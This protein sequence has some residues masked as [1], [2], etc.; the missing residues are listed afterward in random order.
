MG[1][2]ITCKIIKIIEKPKL[3][4]ELTILGEHM[5]L[6]NHLLDEEILFPDM[7]SIMTNEKVAKSLINRSTIG[8]IH[9]ISKTSINPIY[10]QLSNQLQGFC[11]AFYSLVNFKET[12]NLNK[13]DEFFHKG[14]TYKFIIKNYKK[15]GKSLLFELQLEGVN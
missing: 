10:V 1:H 2:N 4:L 15:E 8:V 5:N 11:S 12:Q 14:D 9:S 7:D 13:L 3:Q 6:E